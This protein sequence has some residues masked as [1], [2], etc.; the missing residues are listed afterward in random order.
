MREGDIAQA[1][2]QI[3]SKSSTRNWIL[4]RL[5]VDGGSPDNIEVPGRTGYVVVSMGAN[6]DQG[7]T[8]AKDK[9]G[10]ELA[11]FQEVRMRRELGELV[12]RE[13]SAYAGGNGGGR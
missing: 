4:G 6:G 11:V 1:L 2:D 5:G 10:V 13:A 8:I 3:W 9:V 12:I 7:I